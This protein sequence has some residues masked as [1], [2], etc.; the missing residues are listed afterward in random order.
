MKFPFSSIPTVPAYGL[1]DN[2]RNA[3]SLVFYIVIV[4]WSLVCFLFFCHGHASM[5]L[6][7]EF[8]R[9]FVLSTSRL[10]QFHN[11]LLFFIKTNMINTSCGLQNIVLFRITIRRVLT[12]QIQDFGTAMIESLINVEC[13]FGCY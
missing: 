3:K 13:C 2:I 8:E 5:Y 6:T 10:E 1:Q 12:R 11:Y 4:Y 7:D 9:P